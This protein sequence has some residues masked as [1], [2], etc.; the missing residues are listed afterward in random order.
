MATKGKPENYYSLYNRSLLNTLKQLVEL[1]V[2]ADELSRSKRGRP[3]VYDSAIVILFTV[4]YLITYVGY[5][6]I[7]ALLS[8]IF[9]E[10]PHFN[11]L[12]K[13]YY[14][15]IKGL[16]K[17]LLRRKKA[18]VLIVDTTGLRF[19]RTFAHRG[20]INKKNPKMIKMFLGIDLF[21]NLVCIDVGKY[22]KKDYEFL[23]NLNVEAEI[24]IADS[25]FF[26]LDLSL[27]TL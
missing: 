14:G 18:K 19:D 4:L 6:K 25:G 26:N 23:R 7:W 20:I 1:L 9:D 10:I 2:K 24:L 22:S 8:M 12:Y 11:T 3:R 5:R 27:R 13:R 15:I 21:Y 16:F 17:L